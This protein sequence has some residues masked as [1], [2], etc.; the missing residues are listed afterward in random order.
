MRARREQTIAVHLKSSYPE[1][2]RDQSLLEV[3]VSLP[4][5]LC[6]SLQTNID[7]APSA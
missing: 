6:E 1:K 3:K 2:N 7:D 4:A 5:F